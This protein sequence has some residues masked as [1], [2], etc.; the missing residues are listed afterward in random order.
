MNRCPE[1]MS[2]PFVSSRPLVSR[3]LARGN[4][5][6]QVDDFDFLKPFDWFCEMQFGLKARMGQEFP[7]VGYLWRLALGAG[8][9]EGEAPERRAQVP[10]E[11]V[12]ALCV[13]SLGVITSPC[14][15]IKGRVASVCSRVEREKAH[16]ANPATHQDELGAWGAGLRVRG[17]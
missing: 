4:N 12:T 3:P 15:W 8:P 1:R 13:T 11:D 14:A 6:Q 10:R 5:N 2:R 16:G 7:A 9:R 17:L